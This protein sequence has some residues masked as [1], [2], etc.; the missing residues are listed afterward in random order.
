M[1]R[2]DFI[3]AASAAAAF[4]WTGAQADTYPSRPIR[5]VVTQGTGS[6][7]DI[8]GRL[9]AA[10]LGDRLKQSVFVE[11][12]VGGGGIIGHQFVLESPPDGYNLL[13]STTAPLVVVPAMNRNA[14]FRLADYTAVASA[15]RSPYMVVVADKPGSPASLQDLGKRLAAG[16]ASYS[17]SG[18]GTLTHLATEMY[19]QQAGLKATHVPYK[20]S[21]QSLAD[22]A[23]G[24]VLFSIDSPIAVG[25]LVRAG[26]LRPL[27]VTSG[28]RLASYPD[29]P[30]MAELGYPAL[31]IT[32]MGGLFG[33]PR[34][35]A[36]IVERIAREMASVMASPDV[37][38]Q[39]A[40]ME[41]EPLTMP[42]EAFRAQMLKDAPTWERVVA[43][44]GLV[45]G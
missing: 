22:L 1:Q 39:F 21:G 25:S 6:G 38:A 26:R 42:T 34:L 40:A 17:S 35:P 11:N 31:T 28:Q 41:T 12:K 5:L 32:T 7:S 18:T 44:L 30:T 33:P 29:V 37:V 9:L 20:G 24:Q 10:K 45:A 8:I 19:L 14:K 27:A 13:L 36:P 16:D 2:R 43:R 23:G 4:G 15:L 3:R